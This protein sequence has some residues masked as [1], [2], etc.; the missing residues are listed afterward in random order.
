MSMAR[1]VWPQGA[2]AAALGFWLS[3]ALSQ[4]WRTG[5]L[6]HMS[7]RPRALAELEDFLAAEGPVSVRRLEALLRLLVVS[8]VVV[9]DPEGRFGVKSGVPV[10]SPE[11]GVDRSIVDVMLDDRFLWG[12]SSTSGYF[13][14][15]STE[16]RVGFARTM[17][18]QLS[19]ASDALTPMLADRKAEMAVDVGGGTGLLVLSLVQS[20]HASKGICLDADAEALAIG[21]EYAVS[22]GVEESVSFLPFDLRRD[23]LPE[24]DLYVISRVLHDWD[25]GTCLSLLQRISASMFPGGRVVI[26][27][28]VCGPDAWCAAALDF[29]LASAVGDGRTRSIGQL[30][31]LCGAAGLTI[32]ERQE[33]NQCTSL[34]LASQIEKR[35]AGA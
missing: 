24:G 3:A 29:F 7:E 25:D 35:S 33:V 23:P 17:E 13:S 2:R 12:G 14:G 31:A 18:A 4:A 16:Q 20:G 6:R 22:R 9:P 32:Y 19:G 27:E 11:L 21:K 5:L 8:D 1:Q 10:D 15:L 26:H 34:L 30:E 28:E